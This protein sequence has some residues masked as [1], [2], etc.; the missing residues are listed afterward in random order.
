MV[1][2]GLG[3]HEEPIVIALLVGFEPEDVQPDRAVLVELD[4]A[5]PEQA[6]PHHLQ[7]PLY[8]RRGLHRGERIAGET[9]GLLPGP[10]VLPGQPFQCGLTQRPRRWVGCPPRRWAAVIATRHVRAVASVST[11]WSR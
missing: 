9:P 5:P 10:P 4:V 3:A 11:R 7:D 8:P 1:R 6:V 2:G